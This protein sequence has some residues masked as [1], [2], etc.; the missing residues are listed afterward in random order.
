MNHTGLVAHTMSLFSRK[1]YRLADASSVSAQRMENG[2][3]LHQHIHFCD[4]IQSVIAKI[5]NAPIYYPIYCFDQL[6]VQQ[7]LAAQQIYAPILW[8]IDP[9]IEISKESMW[10]YTH[11]LALP[12]DQRYSPKDLQRIIDILNTI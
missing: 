3:Y 9:N 6:Y 11:L 4:K 10:I 8:P 12:V 1:L 2:N 7:R 5:D